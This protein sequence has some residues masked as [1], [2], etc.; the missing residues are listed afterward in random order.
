[1]KKAIYAGSFDPLTIGHQWIIS[2]ASKIFDEVLVVIAHNP[3]KQGFFSLKQKQAVVTNFSITLPNVKVC[4]TSE[5]FIANF[6]KK[7]KV[8]WIVRG[9]R[10]QQDLDYESS[11]EK[12]NKQINPDLQTIYFKSPDTLSSVS[13]SLVKSLV[14][15][16]GWQ[17]EVEKLV[18]P[19]VVSQFLFNMNYEFLK[20]YWKSPNMDWFDTI[21]K[22]HSESHRFY[23]NTQHLKNLINNL[24]N[25]K[26]VNPLDDYSIDVLLYS[27][28][29]HD[30]IYD[31]KRNDN[32]EES[33]VLWKQF[34]KENNISS[35]MQDM[36]SATILATKNHTLPTTYLISDIFLDLDLSILGESESRFE[37]YE[38]SIRQEYG[39]VPEAIFLE[40]R[41]KIMKSFSNPYR[42]SW[43]K[44]SFSK[45]L[46]INLTKYQS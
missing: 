15:F 22:K 19:E 45:N 29:F 14:G 18:N 8:N 33:E 27:I 39:W 12:I 23:H 7:H 41:L 36:V 4:L 28:F 1:M 13:S 10:N 37:E 17:K 32:E 30:S 44:K 46:F 43:A 5:E 34:A 20:K 3:Q 38:D 42:T 31:T 21:L 40:N 35:Q 26:K 16:I 24:E 25:Y 9:F 2:E 11:I 6:A